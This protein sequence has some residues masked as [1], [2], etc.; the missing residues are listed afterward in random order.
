MS[1]FPEV[2]DDSGIFGTNDRDV[3]GAEIP[4]GAAIA[5]QHSALFAQG[6]IEAG[7]VKSARMAQERSST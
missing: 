4:I 7:T 5:D 2:K 3:L 6:C 1:I